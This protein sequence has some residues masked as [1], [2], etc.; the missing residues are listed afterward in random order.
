MAEP[1]PIPT[2]RLARRL[3]VALAAFWSLWAV[4]VVSLDVG[5]GALGAVAVVLGLIAGWTFYM[6]Y[7]TIWEPVTGL[8]GWRLFL[9][10]SWT[11]RG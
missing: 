6:T 1:D 5:P 10:P 7:F 11:D 4:G 8:S 2:R 3:V 9:A